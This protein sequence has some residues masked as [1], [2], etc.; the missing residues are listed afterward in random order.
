MIKTFFKYFLSVYSS[1]FFLF[2]FAICMAVATFIEND[3]G[4]IEA[5]IIVFNAFWFELLLGILTIIFIYNI[6]K[7][8]LYIRKKIPIL[9]LHLSFIFI[10]LGAGVTRYYSQEGTMPISEGESENTFISTDSYLDIEFH[11]T[12]MKWELNDSKRKPIFFSQIKK[13]KINL[14]SFFHRLFNISPPIYDFNNRPIYLTYHDFIADHSLKTADLIFKS[15]FKVIKANMQN[16]NDQQNLDANKFHSFEKMTPYFLNN[17]AFLLRDVQTQEGDFFLELITSGKEVSYLHDGDY[18]EKGGI[19]F[20][21][22]S[23]VIADVNISNSLS[24]NVFI[25]NEQEIPDLL[26]IKLRYLDYDTILNLEGGIGIIGEPVYVQLDSLFFKIS[27]GSREINLPF[28]IKLNDFQMERYPGSDSPSSYASEI[29]VIPP[30]GN[31]DEK[32]FDYRVYMNN[33]LNYKGYRFFQASY[34]PDETG[35]ILSVNQDRAGT[36]VTYLGYLMLLISVIS[37]LISKSTRFGTLSKRLN[38]NKVSSFLFFFLLSTSLFS[39]NQDSIFHR[40]NKIDIKKSDYFSK[41]LVEDNDGRIK[42]FQSLSSEILRKISKKQSISYEHKNEYYK[43]NSNQILLGMILYPSDW[44]K[45]NLITIGN[46]ENVKNIFPIKNDFLSYWDF[47]KPGLKV[48][49]PPTS[50]NSLDTTIFS[51]DESVYLNEFNFSFNKKLNEHINLTLESGY[52]NINS[53]DTIKYM[54]LN[55]ENE[56]QKGLVLPNQIFSFQEKIVFTINRGKKTIIF[57]PTLDLRAFNYRLKDYVETAY[58]K[59]PGQRNKFDNAIIELDERFNI[60][61]IIFNSIYRKIDSSSEVHLNFFPTELPSSIED[62]NLKNVLLNEKWTFDRI[63]DGTNTYFSLIKQ[64]IENNDTEKFNSLVKNI[65]NYQRLNANDIIPSIEKI[66]LEIFYN[67]VNPFHFSRLLFFYLMF[68]FTLLLLL[69][70]K[71]FYEKKY[72][73]NFIIKLLKFII[74][75]GFI[76]HSIFLILRSIISGHAPWSDAY[77]SLIFISWATLLSGLI[78]SK[79][80]NFS[81]AGA[82]IV[83]SILLL[84]AN[85][86]WINPEITNLVPVLN[87]YW[88][89]IHVSIIT[90]SYGFLALSAFLGLLTLFLIL[91]TKKSNYLKINHEI[92]R[93]VGINEICMVIGLFLLTIGTFL[94]GVWAN[95]SWGRYWG[96]DPKETWALISVIVYSI[97]LHIRLISTKRFKYIFSVASFVGF[98]SI[99]MTYFGVNFYLSGLH[100]YANGEPPPAQSWIYLSIIFAF[101][102]V[103]LSGL[104]FHFSYL[105]KISSK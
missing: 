91:F 12:K 28:S 50:L 60:C 103:T 6:F 79:K 57:I 38:S 24:K 27:Y 74:F 45:M 16:P 81:L 71:I 15:N 42:P 8:K 86:N 78:F 66:N 96:W 53:P 22:N 105:K 35:T 34:F 72:F 2:V 49:F 39:S 37:V 70:I 17:S 4:T 58:S 88:L 29:S 90:S 99:I 25:K 85:L 14:G 77:E 46:N 67:K 26:K 11:N 97:I 93:L 32:I 87:S 5:K 68:G 84:V 51:T 52:M 10:L 31:F 9:F 7:Y 82:S 55:G 73:L 56:G 48:N 104:K 89:M 100:S 69:I 98:A 30:S 41:V 21:F 33:I 80:S 92:K 61:H 43:I 62:K 75:S 1:I 19:S 76:F 102:I 18:L 44:M 36:I 95:E 59:K 64:S 83:G 63:I 13:N 23:S 20:S 65:I 101:V 3:F 40:L 54:I 47:W 94:G